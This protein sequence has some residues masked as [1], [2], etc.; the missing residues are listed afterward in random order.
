MFQDCGEGFSEEGMRAMT[1]LT[2]LIHLELANAHS[3]EALIAI[4]SLT[5]IS[6][7]QL[8]EPCYG[9]E[10]MR[11]LARLTTLTHLDIGDDFLHNEIGYEEYNMHL[12]DQ[13]ARALRSLVRLTHLDIRG[14]A[15]S[16]ERMRALSSF[17]ALTIFAAIFATVIATPG[18]ARALVRVR[19]E[20][21]ASARHRHHPTAGSGREH[22]HVLRAL[23]A[24][25]T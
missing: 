23:Y 1:F 18:G 6:H 24:F 7:L 22:S 11:A 2:G 13:G 12:S 8:R 20:R 3:D 16:D 4:S 15:I 19:H 10:G 5:T 14:I 9:D 25:Y 17:T 21:M